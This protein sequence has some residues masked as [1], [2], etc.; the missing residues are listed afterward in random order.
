MEQFTRMG[1]I[2]YFSVTGLI[3]SDRN[4][5]ITV[6]ASNKAGQGNMS[7]SVPLPKSLG[8]CYVHIYTVCIVIYCA[9]LVHIIMY[10]C[11]YVC[12]YLYVCVPLNILITL[13]LLAILTWKHFKYKITIMFYC[14]MFQK[15]LQ[16]CVM[17]FN[18]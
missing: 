1:D 7:I 11:T 17:C 5:T 6:N 2:F 12:S 9:V 3:N 18:S 15:C 8:K 13:E 10:L 4:V 16:V 14:M